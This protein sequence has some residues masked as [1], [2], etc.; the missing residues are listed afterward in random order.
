MRKVIC[1]A[2][3]QRSKIL[4]VRKKKT[5]ILPGGKPEENE[6]DLSCLVREFSQELPRLKLSNVRQY[7]AIPGIAPHKGDKILAIIYLAD[8]SGEITPSAEINASVWSDNPN[9]LNLS[10]ATRETIASLRQDGYL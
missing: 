6:D 5:W 8:A 4:L 9:E 1:A 7:K 3:I 2:I 10:D